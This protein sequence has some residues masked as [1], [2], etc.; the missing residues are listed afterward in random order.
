MC[1]DVLSSH[2]IGITSKFLL[3]IGNWKNYIDYFLK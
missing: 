1:L 3:V 2:D